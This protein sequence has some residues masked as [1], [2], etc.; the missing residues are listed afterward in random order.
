MTKN[1]KDDILFFSRL[2]LKITYCVPAEHLYYKRGDSNVECKELSLKGLLL[3]TPDVFKDDRGFFFESYSLFEY[4]DFGIMHDFVQDN[5]SRSVKDTIR[6]LHFQASPG[7]A[8]LIRVLS[9][10]IFDVAVDIRPESSACGTWEGVELS[11]EN[12]RQIYIPAGFAHGFAVLSDTAEV[13]YKCSVPYDP[14]KER[15]IAWDDP[16]IGIDWP[17]AEPVLSERDRR[18]IPLSKYLK[19][20]LP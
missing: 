20:G 1:A 3:I 11:A 14:G 5:H 16:D 2:R 17:V 13:E 4:G 18:G 15:T 10:T 9:G 8:K 7:Q 19:D 12:F 6:G